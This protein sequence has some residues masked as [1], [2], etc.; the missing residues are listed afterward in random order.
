MERLERKGAD[1]AR[2]M[3]EA[4]VK[5]NLDEETYERYFAYPSSKGEGEEDDEDEDEDEDEEEDF[6]TRVKIPGAT[7][8]WQKRRVISRMR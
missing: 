3:R 8:R 6:T 7:K 4:L 2:P 1:A 5:P